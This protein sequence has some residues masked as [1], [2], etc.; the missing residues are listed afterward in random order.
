MLERRGTGLWAV[1]GV[2][3]KGWSCTDVEDVGDDTETC[4]MC[5]VMEIRYVHVMHHRDYPR[6]LRCGC[7]CAGNMEQ[8]LVGARKRETMVKNRTRRWQAW[9]R[10]VWRTSARGNLF[11]RRNGLVLGM[12]KARM[13][14]WVI[15]QET[16]SLCEVKNNTGDITKHLFNAL[17]AYKA[18]PKKLFPCL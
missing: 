13:K 6:F 7:V 14:G 15:H 11:V 4:Q 10:M 16:G 8:D 18:D 5:Q 1:A 17:E 3:H 2:P 9:Q 12:D